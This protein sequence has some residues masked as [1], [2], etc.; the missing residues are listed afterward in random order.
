MNNAHGTHYT[1]EIEEGVKHVLR[2]WREDGKPTDHDLQFQDVRVRKAILGYGI[3]RRAIAKTALLG[4]A[5]PLWSPVPP[6]GLDH[7]DFGEQFAYDPE[8]AKFHY[9]KSGHSGPVLFRTSD[10]AFPGAVDAAQVGRMSAMACSSSVLR[11]GFRSVRSG[12]LPVFV[13][14]LMTGLGGTPMPSYADA[15]EPDQA[16]DVVYYVLSLSNDRCAAHSQAADRRGGR[17]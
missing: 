4:Q 17:H 11:H 10:V 16:W 5:Q 14:T 8:K 1:D 13:A 6:G 7:L 3:D 2:G 9:Q 15:L 12:G